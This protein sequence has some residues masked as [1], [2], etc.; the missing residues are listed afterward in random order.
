MEGGTE[1]VHGAA[2]A[3]LIFI[4]EGQSHRAN[5][6]NFLLFTKNK[7]N[8][9]RRG[10]NNTHSPEMT[11]PGNHSG[12]PAQHPRIHR[13]SERA[14]LGQE[15]VPRATDRPAGLP[16]PGMGHRE[17]RGSL[18]G[19]TKKQQ[20]AWLRTRSQDSNMGRTQPSE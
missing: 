11:S 7:N 12:R 14:H 4:P 8:V 5:K 18:A 3:L 9:T 10:A 19:C 13:G 1:Q 16:V 17:A 6:K 2:P 15:A 20:V